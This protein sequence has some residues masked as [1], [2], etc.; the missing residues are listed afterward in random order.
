MRKIK[1]KKAMQQWPKW[2]MI[3]EF[4]KV[5][6]CVDNNGPAKLL[7]ESTQKY[8]EREKNESPGKFIYNIFCV[9]ENGKKKI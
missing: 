8:K 4:L 2:Q 1:A 7:Y 3:F 5:V 9:A 6:K